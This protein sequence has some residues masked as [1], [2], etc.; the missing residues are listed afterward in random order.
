MP[1]TSILCPQCHASLKLPDAIPLGLKPKCPRCGTLVALPGGN[2]AGATSG[3]AASGSPALMP[4]SAATA[5]ASTPPLNRLPGGAVAGSNGEVV[6]RSQARSGP[7]PLLALAVIA[8]GGLL[9]LL[10]TGA[11]LAICLLGDSKK[12]DVARDD[13]SPDEPARSVVVKSQPKKKPAP[14]PLITLTPEDEKKVDAAT[15]RAVNYL[16]GKQIMD[17]PEKGSWKSAGGYHVGYTGLAGLTLLESKVPAA[18]PSVQSAAQYVRARV[19]QPLPNYET[20]QVAVA[21]LFLSRLEDKTDRD[22]IR[23]LALRLAAS[24]HASGAWPYVSRPLSPEQQ[25]L[26]LKMLKDYPSYAGRGSSGVL[27]GHQLGAFQVPNYKDPNFYRGGGDNSNT[28]FALFALWA[29]RRHDLPVDPCLQ[30]VA[31]RFRNSQGPDGGWGYQGLNSV[32]QF[33]T[34]TCVGLLGLAVG[35]G[36]NKDD[37]TPIN[38]AQDETLQKG[39]KRLAQNLG[40]PGQHQGKAPPTIEMYFLWSVERVAVMYQLSKIEGKDWYHWGL[41]ILLAHQQ[42]DGKWQMNRGPGN[43]DIVDT[44]FALLFLQRANLAQDLTDKLQELAA[45]LGQPAAGKN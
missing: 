27:A 31:K 3:I 25:D 35:Y 2:G 28:Q 8:G 40:A 1:P 4:A 6:T 22:L 24:Q 44:C 12:A 18:D 26:L 42:Q 14:R 29:A 37:K 16:K 21:I 38:L 23:S 33:P 5:I 39:F 32:S 11:L 45:L 41:E 13:D 36:L 15:L 20:Y 10:V 19:I 7:G 30:L 34:M 9:L 17:G 43:S